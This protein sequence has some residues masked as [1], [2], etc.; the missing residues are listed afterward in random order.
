MPWSIRP[1]LVLPWLAFA[2]GPAG[3]QEGGTDDTLPRLERAVDGLAGKG[4]SGTVLIAKGGRVLLER[5]FGLAERESGRECTL[6]TVYDI[7][8]I[9][10]QFTGAAILKLEM[11]GKLRVTDLLSAHLPGV[12]ADKQTMSLHHLLTHSSGLIDNLPGGDYTEVS[13][14]QLIEGALASKLQGEPGAGYHYSNL[15]FSVLAAVVELRSGASYDEFCAEHLFEPAGMERTGYALPEYTDDELCVGYRDG[16]SFG[17]PLDH[18]WDADGPWWNLRGNGGILSTARD[19]FQWHA[20][21]LGDTVLSAQAKAKSFARHV[22]E[23]AARTSF[24][25][26]GWSIQPLPD[27]VEL[28]AHNG[29]NGFFFADCWR[30]PAEDLFLFIATN[31][32][33]RLLA[34]GDPPLQRFL[35][36]ARPPREDR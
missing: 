4:A 30:I 15:G 32:A 35:Q 6:E 26:Y 16:K 18:A 1:G 9:T 11:Q 23:D 34:L 36:I 13:R 8:S 20:A 22:P 27:G 12:P 33:R 19:M 24:Y 14:R 25:G 28:I 3:V 17:T 29:G 7:G 21:L 2:A 31:D 10:K 5:A